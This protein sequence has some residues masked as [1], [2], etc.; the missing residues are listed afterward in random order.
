MQQARTGQPNN[1]KR[2]G[3]RHEVEG[4]EQGVTSASAGYFLLV[5]K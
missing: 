3:E 1:N 5:Y 4:E 2:A